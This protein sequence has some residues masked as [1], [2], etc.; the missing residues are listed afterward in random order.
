MRVAV[1]A[2]A[3]IQG[4]LCLT[5]GG[6]QIFEFFFCLILAGC[7]ACLLI[8]FLTPVA[9]ILA[10]IVTLADALSWLPEAAPNLIGGKLAHLELI[11]L[12][13]AIALLGPGAFSLDARLFGRHVIVIP[14]A[15]RAS[16][17]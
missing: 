8:G 3:A 13:G 10:A 16:S 6:G 2:I 9:S 5:H 12:A 4:V 11:V 1:G 7:G 17:S 15:S 14:P